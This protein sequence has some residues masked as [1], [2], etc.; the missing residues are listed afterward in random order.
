MVFWVVKP[1]VLVASPQLLLGVPGSDA[2]EPSEVTFLGPTL[3]RLVDHWYVS[4]RAIGLSYA[5]AACRLLYMSVL[6]FFHQL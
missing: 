6:D 1:L 3:T 2:D 4:V 5:N